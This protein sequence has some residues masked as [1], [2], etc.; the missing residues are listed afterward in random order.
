MIYSVSGLTGGS[1]RREEALGNCAVWLDTRQLATLYMEWQTRLFKTVHNLCRV[2]YCSVKVYIIMS[3]M[4]RKKKVEE[5]I[6]ILQNFVEKCDKVSLDSIC[7][8]WSYQLF[9]KLCGN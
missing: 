1:R 5:C 7:D 6:G 4:Q 8:I 2:Q 3:H 9:S